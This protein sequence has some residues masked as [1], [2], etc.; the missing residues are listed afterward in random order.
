MTMPELQSS[1]IIA[2]GTSEAIQWAKG[3]SWFPWLTTETQKVNRI[4]SLTVA[5]LAG[6]GMSFH[7]DPQAG[8]LVISGLAWSALA[9]GAQQW[10]A[11]QAW[12][13]LAVTK[14]DATSTNT[15]TGAQVVTV[16][17]AQEP[18]P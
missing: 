5:F 11:Q 18:H 15:R 2:V 17:G 14:S 4:V 10:V 1:A 8:T 7:W 6:L 9:H 3:S 16:T 12:Y 13:R